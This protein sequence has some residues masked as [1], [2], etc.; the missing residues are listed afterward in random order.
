MLEVKGNLWTYP[1]KS[2][3]I[4]TNGFIKRT[5][6][7]VMGRGCALEAKKKYA[8]LP[9][10]IG[11]HIVKFGNHV[12]DLGTA[13]GNKGWSLFT[14]PVK[15]NWW[16]KA[17]ITLIARSANELLNIIDDIYGDKWSVVI[18]RPGCGNGK[19]DWETEVKPVLSGIFDDRFIVITY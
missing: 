19:L 5:G 3:A 6:E 1:A 16:E 7:A 17:D 12:F 14:F 15:H 2:I 10:I 8:A 13:A 4:T 18:P 11:E 9:G